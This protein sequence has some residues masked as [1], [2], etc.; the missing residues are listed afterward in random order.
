MEE[1]GHVQLL[2][3]GPEWVEPCGGQR[4]APDARPDR[5]ATQPQVPD[6]FLQLLRCEIRVLQRHGR[7]AHESII[8]GRADVCNSLV[9][10]PDQP[11]GQALVDL[12]PE[13]IDAENL[14]IDAHF[15]HGAQTVWADGEWT[16][17]LRRSSHHL[18][19]TCDLAVRVKVDD[20]TGLHHGCLCISFTAVQDKHSCH[21]ACC[22][23]KEFSAIH[24][25]LLPLADLFRPVTPASPPG[26][27]S[28]GST[29]R[30]QDVTG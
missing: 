13:R 17:G 5:A 12:V 20:P 8:V 27:R 9:L 7:E 24:D 21:G 1:D 18:P 23:F 25:P 3:L 2:G 4:L 6:A 29:S 10:R 28:P 15:I 22:S 16:I 14:E 26:G 11:A 19:D 30:L